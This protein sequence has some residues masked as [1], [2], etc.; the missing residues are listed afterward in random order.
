MYKI[1]FYIIFIALI[2]CSSTEEYTKV[3]KQE[4]I[5]TQYKLFN[6]ALSEFQKGKNKSAL[7]LFK[8]FEQNYS[9]SHL[10]PMSLLMISYIY[11]DTN[12]Y[13]KSLE[14]LKK[15]KE[16]YPKN[17]N[18]IYAEFLIGICLFEQIN[19]VSKDQTS[20]S[21]ALKQFNKIIKNF[22]NSIYSTESKVRI[23]LINEQLAGKEMYIARYYIKKKKWTS[24]IIR[25]EK[26]LEQ[27]PK[28][29]YVDEALHRLVEIYYK[30]GNIG[31]AR[32]Y[33]AILGYNFNNSDWYKETYKIIVDKNYSYEKLELKKK[34]ITDS[35][36][37]A[38]IS[39]YTSD[40]N[41]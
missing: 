13:L 24:A 14:N 22:P 8:K 39:I 40:K 21:L 10:T 23:D 32:K 7:D 1:F 36:K 28:T 31:A 12:D 16:L 17:K 29:I 2:S 9:Y 34:K 38:I 6:A 15:F 30:H 27:Y 5:P 25:L 11:Y 41:D 3:K 18:I 33:A 20:T 35:I 19:S 4:V 37:D 26:I